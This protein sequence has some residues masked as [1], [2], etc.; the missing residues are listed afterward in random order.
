M[1]TVIALARSRVIDSVE[2]L[3]AAIVWSSALA[4]ILA[5]RVLPF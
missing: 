3:R 2:A 5:G 1:A 4:L